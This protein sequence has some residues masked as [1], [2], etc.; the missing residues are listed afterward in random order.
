MS[1]LK[2]VALRDVFAGVMAPIYMLAS[3]LSPKAFHDE[4]ME[5]D[6]PVEE[7]IADSAYTMADFLM[8]ARKKL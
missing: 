4:S 3:L 1:D 5:Q 8:K 7:I 2:D 6:K